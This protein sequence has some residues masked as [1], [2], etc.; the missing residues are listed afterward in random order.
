[1]GGCEKLIYQNVHI[2]SAS[3][4]REASGLNPTLPL[5]ACLAGVFA[6][7]EHENFFKSILSSV[8]YLSTLDP[9][10]EINFD[11]GENPH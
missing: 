9:D 11:L 4:F 10:V 5:T 2:Q 1:M 6:D 7:E 8:N 3:T